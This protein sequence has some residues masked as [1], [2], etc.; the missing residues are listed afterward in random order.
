MKQLDIRHPFSAKKQNCYKVDIVLV[1]NM[2]DGPIFFIT[3]RRRD[4][5]N[6]AQGT[7]FA[8]SPPQLS[9]PT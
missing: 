1:K 8:V 6:D 4:E 2:E 7:E 9:S 5:P 3:Y